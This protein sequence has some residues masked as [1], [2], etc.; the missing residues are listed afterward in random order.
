MKNELN[1]EVDEYIIKSYSKK[2]I[3]ITYKCLNIRKF[4]YDFNLSFNNKLDQN[5]IL[6]K[7][8]GEGCEL[9]IKTDK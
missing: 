5:D 9:P 1:F 7:I 3:K 8:K 4:N 6:F 2:I